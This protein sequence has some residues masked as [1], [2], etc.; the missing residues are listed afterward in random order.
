MGNDPSTIRG[1]FVRGDSGSVSMVG[2]VEVTFADGSV[3]LLWADGD[4]ATKGIRRM[5]DAAGDHTL[6]NITQADC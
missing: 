3:L 1:Q 2:R 6:I 5:F 4:G